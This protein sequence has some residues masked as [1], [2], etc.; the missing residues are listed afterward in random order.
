MEPNGVSLDR[1]VPFP[2]LP[3]HEP[4]FTQHNRSITADRLGAIPG[5]ENNGR[6]V[7]VPVDES[8]MSSD[9]ENAPVL[10]SAPGWRRASFH[11]MVTPLSNLEV[12]TRFN[13]FVGLRNMSRKWPQMQVRELDVRRR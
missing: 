13:K 3:P 2:P 10:C 4:P 6:N 7:G 8:V 5:R 12:I 9:Q 11:A 1:R